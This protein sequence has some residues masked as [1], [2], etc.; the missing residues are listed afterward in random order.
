MTLTREQIESLEAGPEMDALVAEKI[1]GWFRAMNA[2]WQP[3]KTLGGSMP[4][5]STDISAAWSVVDALANSCTWKLLLSSEGCTAQL[6][7]VPILLSTGQPNGVFQFANI[8]DTPLVLCR[9]ALLSTLKD[10][11]Q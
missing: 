10:Q 3:D 5:Y 9:A 1:M 2:W 11:P 7:G 4:A 8:E 6:S